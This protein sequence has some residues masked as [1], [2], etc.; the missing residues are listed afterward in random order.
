MTGGTEEHDRLHAADALGVPWRQWGPY[1]S[2]RQW[3]TVRE[4]YSENG[5][6]WS[7]FTFDQ[8]R[9]RAYRSGEDGLAG[10][11]DD[12]Q[13]VCISLALWN[14]ADPF[15]KERLFGLTNAEGNHGEDVKEYYFHLDAT[16]TH[17]YQRLLYKYP[18]R[19]FPYED[20]VATNRERTR[21]E[22]EYE[23]L[24]T[25]VFDE[26][27]YFDVV[28]EYAKAAPDDLCMRVTA[29]N[30]GPDD[31]ELHLVPTVWFRNTWGEGDVVR[32]RIEGIGPGAASLAHDALGEWTLSA[33][34]EATGL[35]CDNESNRAR[36][37]G[38]AVSPPYPKDAI[39]DAIVKGRAD[40]V[41]PAHT[42]TKFAAWQR[43][44]VAPGAA[45]VARLRLRRATPSTAAPGL[46][47]ELDE[48]VA[49]RQR[50]SDAFYETITPPG[51]DE[52]RRRVL[53]QALAGVLWT[54]QFYEF[55]VDR[56]LR[57]H[58]AH[59]MRTPK[60]VGARNANWFHM[61]NG[62]VISMPDKWEYPWFAAWDLAFHTLALE[63]VDPVFSKG[64]IEL[65]LSEPYLHP[66]GQ[67]P[68]YEWNFGD[69]NPPVHAWATLFAYVTTTGE[70]GSGDVSFLREAFKKLLLNF[71]WWVNRKDREGNNLFEGGFLGLDNIG[72][73][74]RSS[75]LPTGGHLEQADGTAWMALYSQNMLELALELAA[76]DPSYE[77]LALKFVQHFFWIA[78]AMDPP[79]DADDEL[80]D[81]EDGFFY[82]VLCL[83]DGSAQ[84]LKIR[85]L[86]GLLPMCAVTVVSEATLLQFPDITSRVSEYLQRNADLL[87][88]IADPTV[89]GVH[90]RRL[91][92]V[93]NEPKLRRVLN[94]MLDEERFLSPH[95][96]RSLSRWHLA[97]PFRFDVHGEHFEVKYLPAESDS[98]LF[99]GNSNWRGPVWFPTNM[100]LIR[101][102]LQYYLYYGDDFTIE[103][104]TGS[105]VQMTLFEV[106]H[107][108]AERLCSIFLRDESGQRPV[109]GPIER[110]QTDP[111]WRDLVLFHEYF[112]GDTGQGLG[113]SHQ[114]GWTAAVARLLQMFGAVTPDQLL[115]GSTR[116]MTQPQRRT[117]S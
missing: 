79:G 111:H 78:A 106:A 31:A 30:R 27:R 90:G 97:A 49:T 36:L 8:A 114:T 98:G 69:V 24:D 81:A 117:T 35:F 110:F 48:V 41:N 63:M 86:V 74:D 1:V 77:D 26:D 46:G 73:F 59:P 93:L 16:P 14:G 2:D 57:D 85:S 6:A 58:D 91:L 61:R 109:Y 28:V 72:V 103:C 45:V 15:L 10:F 68:A 52:D 76:N 94:R 11:C 104:P 66:S 101:A 80:W 22:P 34:P 7:Y 23:L 38:D 55:D 25:G 56:W 54:K 4:D 9:S 12:H 42:G 62:D 43:H 40:A 82:D 51:L 100:L 67:L 95:G 47:T 18:Q 37:F 116:P 71:T 19:A 65:M 32:P 113:A 20:L 50:E 21:I 96:V 44:R 33:D 39:N 99:G 5:D 107:E 60:R 108:L 102:L 17:S 112:H 92:S 105:G 29:T 83:P 89:P 53:R 13:L 64:Q 87:E 88:N 75:P 70:D 3:G 84:R 115:N